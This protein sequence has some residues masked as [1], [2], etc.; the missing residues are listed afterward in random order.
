MH[1]GYFSFQQVI[2]SVHLNTGV[3]HTRTILLIYYERFR[4]HLFLICVEYRKTLL[5]KSETIYHQSTLQISNNR[6]MSIFIHTQ[7][8]VAFLVLHS[9]F[10]D[11]R[12]L[13]IYMYWYWYWYSYLKFTPHKWNHSCYY[14]LRLALYYFTKQYY[15]SQYVCNKAT[16]FQI[17]YI[18][19][20]SFL[21]NDKMADS[22]TFLWHASWE[23]DLGRFLYSYVVYVLRNCM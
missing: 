8:N 20:S 14:L 16:K 7:E 23:D 13:Y 3:W 2:F 21:L 4:Q 10:R 15:I 5:T 22:N 12:V 9:Y 19:L 17:S 1:K 18:D 11:L 6:V